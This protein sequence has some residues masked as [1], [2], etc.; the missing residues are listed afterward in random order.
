MHTIHKYNVYLNKNSNIPKWWLVY[1]T[2]KFFFL[3]LHPNIHTGGWE[4]NKWE[5]NKN[6][7]NIPQIINTAKT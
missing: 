3:N 6:T 7:L 5:N 2:N 1:I 4:G